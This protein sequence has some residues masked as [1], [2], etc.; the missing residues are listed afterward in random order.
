MGHTPGLVGHLPRALSGLGQPE[1]GW[2]VRSGVGRVECP[3]QDTESNS[4]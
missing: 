1:P 3:T 4:C 2:A